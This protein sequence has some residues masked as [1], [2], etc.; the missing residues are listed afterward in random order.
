MKSN[1]YNFERNDCPSGPVRTV[2]LGFKLSNN[3]LGI[4][5]TQ[6]TPIL[7]AR[8]LATIVHV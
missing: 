1:E 7:E 6:P 5:I 2:S 4:W 3:Y 8:Y